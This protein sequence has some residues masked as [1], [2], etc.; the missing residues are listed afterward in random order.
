MLDKRTELVLMPLIKNQKKGLRK[1]SIQ[2][3]DNFGV[4]LPLR[5]GHRWNL[6]GCFGYTW[7]VVPVEHL[8]VQSDQVAGSLGP[9]LVKAGQGGA[10]L[11]R[12]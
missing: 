4:F 6:E 7:T 12:H 8:R 1:P 11:P 5:S 2:F 10:R 9:E 3:R